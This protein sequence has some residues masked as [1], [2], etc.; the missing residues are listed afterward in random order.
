MI[1][2]FVLEKHSPLSA[3][4]DSNLKIFLDGV[5]PKPALSPAGRGISR[6]TPQGSRRSFAPLK[7]GFAQDDAL[8]KAAFFNSQLFTTEEPAI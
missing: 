1:G 7:N 5:I 3:S 6:H 8:N 4:L 2:R